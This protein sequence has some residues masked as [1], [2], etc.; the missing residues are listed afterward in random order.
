MEKEPIIEIKD[1]VKSFD[2]KLVIDGINLSLFEGES[3]VMLGKSGTGKSVIMKCIVRL[4]EADSGQI[5]VFGKNISEC[6]EEELA[7]IRTRIGYLFQEGALYDSMSILENLLF[8]A[9]RIDSLRKLPEKELEK[10]AQQHLDNVGLKDAIDKMP[11]ELSGG[12][13]KRAGLARTLMRSPELIIY[14]EPT[15]G[16]DPFTTV[17]ISNLIRKIQREYD[18]S[19]IIITHDIKCAEITGDRMQVLHGGRI[20]A[21][22]TF[23]ELKAHENEEVHLF[24]K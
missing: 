18:T 3:L 23:D 15:T 5:N 1:L 10:M 17:A 14:D 13:R 4:M 19:S 11:S 2:G 8:P 20:V 21:E 12:M 6:N 7:R 16:L 9:R 24:F 22:G